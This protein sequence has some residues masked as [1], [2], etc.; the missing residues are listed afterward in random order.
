MQKRF[1]S[2]D[3]HLGYKRIFMKPNGLRFTPFSNIDDYTEWYITIHNQQ[4]DEK[5]LVY[6]TGDFSFYSR[7][8]TESLLRRLNGKIHFI[9]GNHDCPINDEIVESTQNL[10]RVKYNKQN[11]VLC[12]Y[13]L[14]TW[15]KSRKTE[16]IMLHGHEHGEFPPIK[17][18]IDIGFNIW[19]RLLE[20]NEIL[21][22]VQFSNNLIEMG[23][24]GTNFQMATKYLEEK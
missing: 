6:F 15:Y 16:S 22:I 21:E 5:D 13:P 2:S 18:S 24:R 11:I 1:F 8:K 20:W 3:H 17:N 12:H 19:G 23:F 9:Y 4:V 14:R 10:K 7:E